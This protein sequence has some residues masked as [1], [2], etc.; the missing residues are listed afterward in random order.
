MISE[1]I[2]KPVDP[3]AAD[4]EFWKRYHQ[5]RRVRH[6]ESRPDDPLRPDDIE[7]L[8]MKRPNPFQ[9]EDRFEVARDG[10]MLSMFRGQTVKPDTPEYETNKHLYSADIYVRP[11][12]RRRGIGA[13]WLPI[14]VEMMDS[15]GCRVLSIGTEEESGHGFLRWL[16]AEARFT[17]A[18]N[19]LDLDTVDWATVER[20]VA[21]GQRRSPQTKLETYDGPLP[22]SMWDDYAPKL[23]DLLN[24]MPWEDLDHGD[25]VITRDHMVDF[26]KRLALN[27]ETECTLVTREPDGVISGMTDTRWAPYH[28]TIIHQGFTGV[29]REARGRGIGKWIKAAMLLHLRDL[30]PDVRWVV[31]DNAGS[32]APMLAI[33]KKLGFK[34]YR[35]GTEYQISRDRL[36]ARVEGLR[37][38]V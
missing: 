17:G 29:R 16:G 6:D 37:K 38:P 31:T 4:R 20:W 1:L 13:S 2:P 34:Q 26:Y 25:I 35:V 10:K 15:R 21:E 22:E 30:Y 24:T 5:I 14:I 36:A 27:Q 23:S 3:A 8:D 32:N 33:N 9:L 28:R 12:H 11:D 18:E 7:E 19:R